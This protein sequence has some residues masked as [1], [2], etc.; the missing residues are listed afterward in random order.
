MSMRI[1]LP[2]CFLI[3]CG[4]GTQVGEN[5]GDTQEE[6]LTGPI[7]DHV[8]VKDAQPLGG[9]VTIQANITDEQ[10]TVLDAKVHYKQETSTT[11]KSQIMTF[12]SGASWTATI[13]GEDVSTAGMHYYIW[14]ID[15]SL[16]ETFKPAD[17]EDDPYHFT[18][19][20]D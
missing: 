12:V 1:T 14:A 8:P 19:D 13:P 3:A 4:G 9:P 7:I 20:V 5:L 18:L 17:G 2:T 15:D 6:D 11:W 16:N 10:G